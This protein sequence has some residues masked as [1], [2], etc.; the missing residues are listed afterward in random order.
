VPFVRDV[1]TRTVVVIEPDRSVL[2]AARKM[3][4]KKLGGLVVVVHG[5][6]VGLITERDI[7]W[8]VTAKGRSPAKVRVRDIMAAPVVTV[9]PL[10]TVRAAARLMI[11]RKIRWLVVTRLDEVEGV[12]TAS[13]LTQGFLEAY[14]RAQKRGTASL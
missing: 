8:N 4:S 7:L 9:S 13:D 14:A 3:A 6:P 10:T 5:R 2:D 1:M 11:E 12:M